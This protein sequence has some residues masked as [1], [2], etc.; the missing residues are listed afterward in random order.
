MLGLNDTQAILIPQATS[1]DQRFTSLI[2][3]AGP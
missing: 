1:I 2:V 3:A